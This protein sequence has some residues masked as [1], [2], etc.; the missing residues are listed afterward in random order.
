MF[1]IPEI[2]FKV[3]EKSS[4]FGV[5]EISPLV[6]GFGHTVASAIRRTLYS[7]TQGSAVTKVVITGVSHEFSTIE[8]AKDD[9]VQI[10]LNLKS[11]RI[12]KDTEEDVELKIEKTGPGDVTAGDIEKVAGVEVINKDLFITSLDSKKNTFKAKLTVSSGYGYLEVDESAT[13]PIGTILLDANYSPIVNVAFTVD[14]ARVGRD[15]N[16]DKLSI[17]VTTDG[18]VDPEDA[19]RNAAKVMKEFFYKIQTGKDYTPEED[20]A[21]APV[22]ETSEG[23][24]KMP[25][26]EIVLEELRLPTRTVNA[27]RKAGIKTLGDLADRS[28]DDLLR[29]RN[30]GEKSIREIISLLEKEGLR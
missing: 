24:G 7:S 4:N 15:T 22:E 5:F 11:V 6:K 9:V 19:V 3:V 16:Y 18:T 27:L 30:L 23:H 29:V 2:S 12:K 25:L 20:L 8:G 10:L 14:P 26:D 1:N 28:E 13:A 17:K 21:M